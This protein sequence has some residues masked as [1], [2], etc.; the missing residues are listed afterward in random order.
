MSPVQ[1]PVSGPALAFSLADELRT[2]HEELARTERRIGRTLVK[3]GPLRVTLVGL[4]AGGELRPHRAAGPITV[5][6][7]EGE[8]EF[9]A[10]GKRWPLAT[11]TLLALEAGITHAVRSAGGGVFL[12]TVVGGARSEE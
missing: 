9:E 1:H 7:L 3:D 4:R 8:V 11:G 5:Q 12:L 10:E 6:V 2:L